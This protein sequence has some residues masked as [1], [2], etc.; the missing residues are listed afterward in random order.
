MQDNH[1]KML[2]IGFFN[3][4]YRETLKGGSGDSALKDKGYFAGNMYNCEIG[5][6]CMK[7][8]I[9][10]AMLIKVLIMLNAM[11]IRQHLINLQLVMEMN[12]LKPV[13]KDN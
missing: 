5:G 9:A 11:I 4:Y 7:I 3:D 8:Q 13:R 1:R 10:T 12:H 2:N 6:E